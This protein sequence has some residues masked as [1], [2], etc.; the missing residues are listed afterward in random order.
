MALSIISLNVNGVRESSKSEGLLQ[1]LRSLPVVV[2]VVCL[3]EAHCVSD[4]ECHTWFSSSGFSFVLSPGTCRSGGCIILYRP[5]LQLVKFWCQVPGRSL[6][7]E[8]TCCGS[9]F[10]VF[11]L[12]APNRNPARD[13]FFNGI[14][15]TVDPSFPT[16]LCGDFNTVFDR[17]LDRFGS[18][19]DDT[20]RESTIALTRLFDSCCVVDIWSYLHPTTSSF[21]WNRWDGQLASRIDLM[22]CPYPWISSVSACDI[23]P[24]PLS[25][26][27]ALLF[28]FSI[29]D[30]IPPGPDLWKLNISIL[31]ETAY[32]KLIT[33]FWLV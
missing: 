4:V 24:F 7:C 18:C 14:S 17:S 22:G 6:L 11:C 12:Y 30:V 19:V 33:D 20:T 13:N 15:D 5:V 21:T 27:C 16:V 8:F 29:P 31:Q 1:W 10:R 28:S 3:Q 25:D 23:V 9:S 32:V 26:H 2:D